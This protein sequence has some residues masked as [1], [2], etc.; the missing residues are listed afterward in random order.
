MDPCHATISI[1]SNGNIVGGYR[2]WKLRD[3]QHVIRI[4]SEE[5]IQQAASQGF[6][7]GADRA[8]GVFGIFCQ[9]MPGGAGETDLMGEQT[10]AKTLSGG[11]SLRVRSVCPSELQV[12][13][14]KAMYKW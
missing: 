4:I 6:D 9:A 1:K 14:V 5:G 11:R 10:H 3:R 13:R 12:S 2:L 7:R 8:Q